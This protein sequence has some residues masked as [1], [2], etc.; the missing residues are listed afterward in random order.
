MEKEFET[1]Q[2]HVH[3]EQSHFAVYPKLTQHHNIVNL[4]YSN[5]KLKNFLKWEREFQV[6]SGEW[7][8]EKEADSA[9]IG[10]FMG[11]TNRKEHG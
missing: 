9:V 6:S 5:I 11:T 3:I 4:L 10:V 7:F 1:E 8:Q 2:I